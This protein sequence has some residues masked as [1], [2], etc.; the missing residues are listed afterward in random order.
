MIHLH[1]CTGTGYNQKTSWSQRV[2]RSA[3]LH[4]AQEQSEPPETRTSQELQAKSGCLTGQRGRRWVDVSV[5]MTTTGA[6]PF[7]NHTLAKPSSG[8]FYIYLCGEVLEANSDCGETYSS[9]CNLCPPFPKDCF[10]QAGKQAQLCDGHIRPFFFG[11]KG[12][13]TANGSKISS[14]SFH[15]DHCVSI[16]SSSTH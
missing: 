4:G 12:R 10:H 7:L 8:L 6:R 16:N 3:P 2:N 1:L 11:K 14:E 13:P 5:E 9:G 15:L